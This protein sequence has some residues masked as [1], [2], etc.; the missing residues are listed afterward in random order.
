MNLLHVNDR[1]GAH[2]PSWYAASAGRVPDHAPLNGAVQADVCIIGGGFTGLSAALH[3]AQRG[4]SVR[5]LEAQRIGFGASG[6]NGGQVGS[7]QRVDQKTLETRMGA[8]D[9]RALWHLGEDAKALVKSLIAEHE[10]DCHWRYGVAH[11]CRLLNDWNHIRDEADLLKTRYGYD[12]LELLDSRQIEAQTGSQVFR[13]GVIDWGAGHL[14]PLRYCLGLAEAAKAAGAVL[15]ERSEVTALHPGTAP[16]V[17][18]AHGNVAARHVILACNGYLGALAPKVAARVMPINNFIVATEP[19]GDIAP[20]ILP[21]DIAVADSRFVVNYWRLSFN[22]RLLFGGGE[23]YGYKFPKD[24]RALVRGP[25]TE[26][27]PQLAQVKLDHAWGGTLAI[28]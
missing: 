6:R 9:A 27:Y 10:I 4:F 20:E 21:R 7:G 2:P 15:H 1:P 24:I 26:V 19:L 13:G 11:V 23:S 22:G 12:Q 25:M 16:R 28:T 18:T 5:L 3:L 17:D 14:H 8:A